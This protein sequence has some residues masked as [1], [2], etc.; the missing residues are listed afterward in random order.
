MS[1]GRVAVGGAL[2]CAVASPVWSQP[3][4]V[5]V[6]VHGRLHYQWNTTSVAAD[7][8]MSGAALATSTFEHRRVRLSAEVRVADWIRGRIEPEF[9]LGQLRLRQTWIA[10]MVDDALTIRAGQF[11]K[12]FNVINVTSGSEVPLIERAA[13]IRGLDSALRRAAGERLAEVRGELLV[14]DHHA[15]LETQRYTAYDMGLAL[16]GRYRGLGWAGGVFNGQGADM[17]AENDGLSAAARVTLRTERP[18]RPLTFGGGWSRR[19]LN[20]PAPASPDTRSGNA[21]VADVQFGGYQRGGLWLLAEAV[22]GENLAT[23]ERF[24]GAQ[25]MIAWL[26]ATTGPRL[27]G[28]EPVARI[29]WGDPD[30]TINGDDGLLLTPGINFYFPGRSRLMLNWDV[31]RPSDDALR[32]QHALRAQVNLEF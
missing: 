29:A 7:E 8:T 9:A 17:R 3:V 2:L 24:A 12:P 30:R 5:R 11:K 25:A 15:L 19:S 27:V 21:F 28:I 32:T 6:E 31:Y 13:R 23:E 20:W 14:G 22:T 1:V 26:Q 16:E 4:P 10:F 18:G